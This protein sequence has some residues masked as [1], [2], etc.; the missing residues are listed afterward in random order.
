[1]SLA[2]LENCSSSAPDQLARLH[3][4]SS[5]RLGRARS[6]RRT[7][8][9]SYPHLAWTR[10]KQIRDARG[11]IRP[12]PPVSR[13]ARRPPPNPLA[14]G[15]APLARLKSVSP[16]T[17]SKTSEARSIYF[18][19]RF[20]RKLN[21]SAPVGRPARAKAS[22][23]TCL[24]YATTNVIRYQSKVGRQSAPVVILGWLANESSSNGPPGA[25]LALRPDQP[26]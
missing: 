7:I 23:V 14:A 25:R 18:Q 6:G 26:T 1:M 21:K 2:E 8:S 13:P 10:P 15:L 4:S 24:I 19:C 5:S 20:R 17:R 11:R 22:L 9:H 16:K 12:A 3:A